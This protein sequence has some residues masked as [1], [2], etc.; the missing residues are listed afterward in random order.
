MT[1]STQ[2]RNRDTGKPGGD[3]RFDGRTRTQSDIT[4][5]GLTQDDFNEQFAV[6]FGS[7]RAAAAPVIPTHVTVDGDYIKIAVAGHRTHPDGPVTV[8]SAETDEVFVEV[9]IYDDNLAN[10]D[11]T[12]EAAILDKRAQRITA[13]KRVYPA[14]VHPALDKEIARLQKLMPLTG[15]DWFPGEQLTLATRAAGLSVSRE[16]NNVLVPEGA[17]YLS[18]SEDNIVFRTHLKSDF[19]A[20][21]VVGESEPSDDDEE[22]THRF[23]GLYEN[24]VTPDTL[25]KISKHIADEYGL[26]FEDSL[27]HG[28]PIT[29]NRWLPP[30]V[31]GKPATLEWARAEAAEGF[32]NFQTDYENGALQESVAGILGYEMTDDGDAFRKTA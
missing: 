25:E 11:V 13:Q 29:L 19:L 21:I 30:E 23:W 26:E 5:D 14:D 7:T 2:L 15:T 3:G 6:Q 22:Q 4:L 31:D 32:L 12:V 24:R 16:D 20:E 28:S 27:E 8:L 17:E 1:T 10:V 9:D 18:V